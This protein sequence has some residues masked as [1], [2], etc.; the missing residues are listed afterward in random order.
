MK[1]IK[2]LI[3]V[4]LIAFCSALYSAENIELKLF[5]FTQAPE[6]DSWASWIREKNDDV[7]QYINSNRNHGEINIETILNKEFRNNFMLIPNAMCR[8][9]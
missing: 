6:R 3:G 2:A 5:I 9:E 1:T 4:L 8:S 7:I